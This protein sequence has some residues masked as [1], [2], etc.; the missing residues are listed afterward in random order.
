MGYFATTRLYVY[1]TKLKNEY[2]SHSRKETNWIDFDEK[3]FEDRNF[4]K[5]RVSRN[6]SS[7]LKQGK[8]SKE[9]YL[10]KVLISVFS[11]KIYRMP[12]S[13]PFSKCFLQIAHPS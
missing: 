13:V 12:A 11:F 8:P 7:C 9:G 5:A 6:V 1:K 3:V 4:L 10:K 2:V